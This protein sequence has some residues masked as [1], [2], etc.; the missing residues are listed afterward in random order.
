MPDYRGIEIMRTVVF[1]AVLALVV[2]TTPDATATEITVQI[3]ITGS[4]EL[5]GLDDPVEVAHMP[6]VSRLLQDIADEPRSASYIQNALEASEVDLERLLALGLLKAFDGAYAIN[7][8]YL[9]LEDHTTLV[10]VLTP[11]A[12]D[13]AQRYRD[14]WSEFETMFAAYDAPGVQ[15]GE[16]AYAVL[17]AMSLDWDGLD[18]TADKHLR[19]TAEDL[20]AGRDFV[21]WAKEQSPEISVKGLYWGSHNAVANGVRF[22][23]F[24]DH[25]TLPR[26]AFPDLLWIAGRKIAD[27]KGAA[28]P[29]RLS[30]YQA[31]TPYYQDDFLSD[32]GP[33]L[34]QLRA[35]PQT[36]ASAAASTGIDEDRTAAILALLKELQYVDEDEGSYSLST[37]FFGIT[38]KPM[39]DAARALSWQMMSDWLD[40][41]AA[42]TEADLGELT[43][44]KYGVPYR[45]LFTEIWHYLFGL[46]NRALVES[47]HFADPYAEERLAKAIVP[48]AFDTGVFDT[49]TEARNRD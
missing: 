20:P 22:T 45:Q 48:F 1:G 10:S 49:R 7:F 15:E 38:D 40:A 5:T 35:G 33:I 47:G 9:T 12:E 13:L 21:L 19:I 24:G 36:A 37:P 29:L 23:S 27:I 39:I 46:T 30:F 44:I 8:N 26:T 25:H 34:R 43:A 2:S 18:L 17:G 28:R 6:E 4:N 42:N 32:L 16:I 31:L 11:Y 3:G 14:R 41:N